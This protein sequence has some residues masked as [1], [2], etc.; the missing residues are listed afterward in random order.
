[1]KPLLYTNLTRPASNLHSAPHIKQICSNAKKV[2]GLI[3]RNFAANNIQNSSAYLCTY[4]L[5]YA[6]QV[7]DPHLLKDI[8]T[9]EN[10]QKFALWV[11]YG[12]FRASWGGDEGN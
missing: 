7:W 9:I 4:V 8:K 5:E 10:V 11:C 3:Y 2:L 1:M 12:P 6:F